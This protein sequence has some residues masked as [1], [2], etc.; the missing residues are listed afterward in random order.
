MTRVFCITQPG[1]TSLITLLTEQEEV[2]SS[3]MIHGKVAHLL[4]TGKGWALYCF[5]KE[6]NHETQA[7]V[8]GG[9]DRGDLGSGS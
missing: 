5:H 9:G 1:V 6:T 7:D 3:A 8:S 4:R 2:F